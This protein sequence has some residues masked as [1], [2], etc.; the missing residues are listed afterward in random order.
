M[1]FKEGFAA[2][3]DVKASGR[4]LSEAVARIEQLETSIGELRKVQAGVEAM[5]L[6]AEASFDA[7]IK[8]AADISGE[9]KE[10]QKVAITL[11]TLTDNILVEAEDRLIEQ[12]EAFTEIAKTL[13]TMVEAAVSRKFTSISSQMESRIAER[14]REELKKT[15]SSLCDALNLNSREREVTL[16]EMKAVILAE[17]PRT[18]FGRRGQR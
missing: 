1:S 11:P 4:K 12:Q 10:F 7:L 13:P 6:R 2:I 16:E 9:C 15:R 17:M 3:E 18:L 14:L 8:T 5:L